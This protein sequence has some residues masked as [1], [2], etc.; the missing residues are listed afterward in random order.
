MSMSDVERPL[1]PGDRA[2]GRP[3][4]R[5]DRAQRATGRSGRRILFSIRFPAKAKSC[6]L[7]FE[8]VAHC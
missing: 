4:D 3:G 2:T 7:I 5:G 6:S 1:R 8:V